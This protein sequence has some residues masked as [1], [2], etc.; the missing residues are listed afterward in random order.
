MLQKSRQLTQLGRGFKIVAIPGSIVGVADLNLVGFIVPSL[1]FFTLSLVVLSLGIA[2]WMSFSKTADANIQSRLEALQANENRNFIEGMKFKFYNN[3]WGG[4]LGFSI[5]I[6]VVLGLAYW[7]YANDQGTIVQQVYYSIAEDVKKIEQNTAEIATSTKETAKHTEEIAKNTTNLKKESS[8]DPRKELANKG[9]QWTRD[10]YISQVIITD[11]ENLTLFYAGGFDPYTSR[12]FNPEFDYTRNSNDSDQ[13]KYIE[14]LTAMPAIAFNIWKSKRSRDVMKLAADYEYKPSEDSEFLQNFV[15]HLDSMLKAK[16]LSE[17]Q[18]KDTLSFLKSIDTN[19][20]LEI[21]KLNA[22]ILKSLQDNTYRN[23]VETLGFWSIKSN[24]DS[25]KNILKRWQEGYDKALIDKSHIERAKKEMDKYKEELVR[26][27][28]KLDR[29]EEVN[30][31]EANTA[32]FWFNESTKRYEESL[33]DKSHIERA[34]KLVDE[35]K[36]DLKKAE[37][38]LQKAEEDRR[39]QKINFHKQ[40]MQ[41]ID[42]LL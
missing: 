17:R 13:H 3:L 30:V 32:L 9:V 15:E 28:K 22:D 26:I 40:Y 31:G 42:E 21:K 34:Q 38:A 16:I 11:M 25:A 19:A 5:F 1:F 39:L 2:V 36:V 20:L 37:E 18:I 29:K 27:K 33:T 6:N 7:A 4:I 24:V 14:R 35:A 41:T 10:D 8:D 12:T 23:Y